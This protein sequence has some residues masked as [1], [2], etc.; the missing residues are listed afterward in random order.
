MLDRNANVN[1]GFRKEYHIWDAVFS[2]LGQGF[3]AP[4]EKPD[5]AGAAIRRLMQADEAIYIKYFQSLIT[6]DIRVTGD[7]TPSY[8]TLDASALRK[9]AQCI[10]D[11]GFEIKVIF[12]MRDPIDRIWSS[13][14][15]EERNKRAR[16]EQLS[17]NFAAVRVLEYFECQQNFKCRQKLS[18]SDYKSTVQNIDK[19]FHKESVHFE[20]YENLFTPSG[21]DR[22]SS[23][24]GFS[25]DA[26]D[27]EKRINDSPSIS[28]SEKT[29][30]ELYK[31][32]KPQYDFCNKRFPITADFWAS[33]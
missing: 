26:I 1:M 27:F 22:L 20:I 32:L 25:F 21:I 5:T 29:S 4:L 8:S 6:S 10:Q 11:G 2:D 31:H 15:M 28:R 12:L 24:L 7:I 18:R 17:E 19:V 9:I 3:R 16:G 23:F 13:V 33:F 14:R 30:R